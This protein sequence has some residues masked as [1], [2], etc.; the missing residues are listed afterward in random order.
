MSCG[1]GNSVLVTVA[2]A[3]FNAAETIDRAIRSAQALD[4]PSIEIVVVDDASA[5]G[6][7]D[8]V[9]QLRAADSRIR[10]IRH[11]KNLGTGATRTRLI[12]EARGEFVAFLDDDDA[13]YPSRLRVQI[14]ALLDAEAK[15]GNTLVACYGSRRIISGLSK[16]RSGGAIARDGNPI[17]GEA[18][19]LAILTGEPLRQG[20]MG[21]H[22]SCTL[23]ARRSTFEAV[24]DF[25]PKF[26]R[27]QDTDWAIRLALMGGAFVGT[28]EVVIDQYITP[29]S[30][31]SAELV[32]SLGIA[33]RIKHKDF[34]SGHWAYRSAIARVHAEHYNEHGPKWLFRLAILWLFLLNPRAVWRPWIEAKRRQLSKAPSP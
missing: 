1:L 29:T 14:A 25:D 31:K 26:R 27:H 22:G 9:E 16:L 5:D 11:H 24:G 18:V 15:T 32:R 8:V 3:S 6:S 33:L 23:L 10:V 19:A 30:D 21:R 34:L 20:L 12:R 2:I 17:T 4:W 28:R 13:C 7:V